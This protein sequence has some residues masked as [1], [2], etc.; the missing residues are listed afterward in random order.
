M[1]VLV[2]F[3]KFEKSFQPQKINPKTLKLFAKK[4]YENIFNDSLYLVFIIPISVTII[5]IQ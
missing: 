1:K 5:Q 3:H 2:V 4:K